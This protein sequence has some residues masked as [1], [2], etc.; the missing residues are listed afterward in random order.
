M[1]FAYPFRQFTIIGKPLGAIFYGND[2]QINIVSPRMI[3]A[4]TRN[5]QYF[6]TIQDDN[7]EV[8]T[9]QVVENITALSWL[10]AFTVLY[11]VSPFRLTLGPATVYYVNPDAV[12]KVLNYTDSK[13]PT[14]LGEISIQGPHNLKAKIRLGITGTAAITLLAS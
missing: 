14:V 5:G 2:R 10:K 9:A 12:F 7:D 3:G 1:A 6:V 4:Y 8:S 11:E 13:N